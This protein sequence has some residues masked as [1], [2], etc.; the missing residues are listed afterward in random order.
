MSINLTGRTALVTGVSAG[1]GEGVARV[2]AAMGAH[3]VGIAR[4]AERGEV[5]AAEI[6]AAGGHLD[7]IAG[8]ITN[9]ACR[10]RAVAACLSATGRL[11]ILINNAGVGGILAPVQ[12]YPD[13]AW[14]QTIAVNLSAA[15][16]LCRLAL[17][18]MRAQRDG[19]ILN[20][21]SI[22]AHFGITKMAAYCAAKAGLVH[23]TKV[24]AAEG[25][26]ANVRAN[27]IILGG[28]ESEMNRAT[29]IAMAQSATGSG[30]VP[31]DERL[32]HYRSLMMKPAD[33]AAALA[34]LCLP[35]AALI[36]G[37]EIAIDQAMTAGAAASALIHG[38][39]AALLA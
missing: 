37:S 25:V 38:G 36:T 12:D 32:A 9:P 31:S 6:R 39:A 8:D 27:A 7:F 29:T 5:L 24:L 17:P 3:V 22:N 14:D 35:E 2:F 30:A 28:V 33:V 23:L 13:T 21:A 11:D 34:A 19:V 26:D 20:I 10:E 16:G 1:L 15:F 18:T 4:R